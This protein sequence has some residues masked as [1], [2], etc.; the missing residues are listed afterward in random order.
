MTEAI[1]GA[2]VAVGL[3]LIGQVGL[4]VWF[5]S[6]INT[7]VDVLVKAVERLEGEL[8]KVLDLK[9]IVATLEERLEGVIARL[10]HLEKQ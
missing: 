10:L 4:A 3:F 2:C 1:I 6:R 5:A 9:A 7:T 8:T